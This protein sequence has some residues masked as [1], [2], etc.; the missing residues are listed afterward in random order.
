MIR[1]FDLKC[2]LCG[3]SFGTT[4]TLFY[5]PNYGMTSDLRDVEFICPACI[6]AWH[7]K[8]QIASAV[9]HEHDYVMTVDLELEDG[10]T[11][12]GMDCTP[13]DETE[14]VVV[15]EDIPV[16]AQQKLYT[17]YKAWDLECKAHML[18]DCTFNDEFMRMTF[19]CETYGGEKYEDVAFR[20]NIKGVLQTAV[21]VPDYV[22]TQIVEAYRLYE[23]QM[24][25]EEMPSE[26]SEEEN[27]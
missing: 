23:S 18:K 14:T 9:F 26:S 11:Y 6:E 22:K 5:R 4:G 19:S 8:W 3:E 21:P 15:G 17:I 25:D 7:K 20:F 12:E 24:N 27:A 2:S 13:L 10:T 16:E 1:Q